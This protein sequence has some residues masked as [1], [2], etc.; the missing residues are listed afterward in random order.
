[1]GTIR[2]PAGD[3]GF[4]AGLLWGWRIF[5]DQAQ[6]TLWELPEVT[7]VA[8]ASFLTLRIATVVT[9]GSSHR[10]SVIFPL[11]VP[12]Q[13]VLDRRSFSQSHKHKEARR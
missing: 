9:S 1:V 13:E 11:I 8:K 12:L 4:F 10:D 5:S 6:F 7:T 2:K 3:G